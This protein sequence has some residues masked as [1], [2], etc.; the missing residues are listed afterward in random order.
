MPRITEMQAGGANECAFLDML[1]WS[2]G[3][4]TSRYTK[5]D[6]Y[7]VIVGGLDSPNTFASY[8]DHPGILVTVNSRGLKSTA[9]GRYQQM[10]RDWPHYKQQLSLPDF[11]PISQD[12]LALQHIRECKALPDIHAGHIEVAI[13]KCRNIWASLP[14][15]GYG[16]REHKMEDLL[17]VYK[18]AGGS[19]A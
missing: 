6:G 9:A 4:S 19:L 10:K 15:A 16:Q 13:I 14:G 3:T 5:D 7:D 17:A 8:A 11:G 1:A 12:R 2:E 18:K